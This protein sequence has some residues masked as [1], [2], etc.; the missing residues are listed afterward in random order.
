[1]LRPYAHVVPSSSYHCAR[2]AIGCVF[3]LERPGPGL[4]M[5]SGV[6]NSGCTIGDLA[7]NEGLCHDHLLDPVHAL[8]D[9]GDLLLPGYSKPHSRSPARSVWVLVAQNT[10]L[11]RR[12]V[13]CPMRM[14]TVGTSHLGSV[15]RGPE[16]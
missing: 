16:A 3:P 13:S 9:L 11:H 8:V 15:V 1:M 5:V 14:S 6:A 4:I 2:A 10:R 7:S 12:A